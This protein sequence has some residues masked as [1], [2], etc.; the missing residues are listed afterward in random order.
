MSGSEESSA[1]KAPR[2]KETPRSPGRARSPRRDPPKAPAVQVHAHRGGAGL[3][4][5]NTMAAFSA[6]EA[7][8]VHWFEFDVRTCA[9]GELVVF[10]DTDLK[11]TAGRPERLDSLSL[12]DLAAADVGSH[13]S[14]EFAGEGVP[15]LIE[16]LE[17]F[18]NQV[19][20]NIEIKEDS[21][22]GDGTATAVGQ[23]VDSMDLY[24]DVILSSFNPLSLRRLRRVCRAPIGLIYPMAGSGSLVHRLRDRVFHRPWPAPLL[25]AYALHPNHEIVD[26]DLVK[27]AHLRGMAVNAWTVNAPQRMEQ[28]ARMKVNGLITDRPD[29]ALEVTG[30]L[31]PLRRPGAGMPEA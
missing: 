20:F 13:F 15:S 17:T 7:L 1:G 28:L 3:A 26:E 27:Q 6:S 31:D 23:L 2:L 5:E 22:A 21:L 24:S 30:R 9:T 8:G 18:R 16:V 25:S 4:P 11:R 29:L 14:S 19:R 12:S 10:H